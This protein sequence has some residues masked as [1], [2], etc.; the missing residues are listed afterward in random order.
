MNIEVQT[1]LVGV[2]LVP[3]LILWLAALYHIIARRPDLSVTWKGIWSVVV[4]F[5]PYVGVFLYGMLRP[6]RPPERTGGKDPTVI[7]AAFAKLDEL[8][9][10]HDEG[11]IDDAQFAGGKRAVFG[12]TD[13][14]V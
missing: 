3:L 6:P 9:T 8:D 7:D 1:F 13:S 5:L 2:V 11:A 4:V 10:A 14:A 12:L